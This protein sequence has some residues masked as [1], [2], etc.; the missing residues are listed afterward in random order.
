MAKKSAGLI[1]FR[2]KA[3]ALE[4]F[5]VHPGGPFWARK[6][7]GCWSIPKGEY[8]EEE[9]PLE[10]AQREFFEETG[11]RASGEFRQLAAIRQPSGKMI[12]AWAFEGDCDAGSVKSNT[13]SLEWPPKSGKQVDFPEVD[14]AAWFGVELA[15]EKILKGQLGFIDQLTALFEET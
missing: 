6:D 10:A 9:D 2:R 7:P 12:I 13:F 4:I 1:M 15:R 5:L 8:Q 14:R 3:G 11:I